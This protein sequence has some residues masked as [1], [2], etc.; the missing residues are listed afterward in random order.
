MR[1]GVLNQEQILSLKG[2]VIE[3]L[4]N[5]DVDLS[6]FDLRLSQQGWEM[7]AS[8]KG[9]KHTSVDK[10][11]REHSKCVLPNGGPWTLETGK[12]YIFGL[13]QYI[14]FP[15]NSKIFGQATGKS[16]IGRLDVLTRLMVDNCS[17]FDTIEDDC[18]NGSLYLEVTPITFPIQV[19]E[20]DALSQLRLFRGKPHLSELKGEVLPLYGPMILSEDGEPKVEDMRTE[21]T[22]DLRPDD[23][24][25][26][27]FITKEK[28]E[29]KNNNLPIDLTKGSDSHDPKDFWTGVGPMD[30]TLGIEPE[31]FYILR[32]RERFRLPPDVAVYCQAISETLGELRI[33]YAG[34]VH[35]GFGFERK[36]GTPVIFE[37]RG[38]NVKVLLQHGETLAHIK[39]YAMSKACSTT[40]LTRKKS[41]Y[42]GQELKLSKYFKDWTS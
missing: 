40:C 18:Y 24:G 15:E 22:V 23:N 3:H 12:T 27:A 8:V 30:G 26:C 16:S 10:I 9:S 2:H 37:V 36:Q 5:E 25:I 19:K 28:G 35:P 14:K 42:E 29:T 31:R 32:S 13:R 39:F 11:T 17:S 7:N 21:L 1:P 20:G 34:F 38:H 4:E 41:G 6:A 33:H